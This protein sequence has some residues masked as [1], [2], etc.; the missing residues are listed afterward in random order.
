MKYSKNMLALAYTCSQSHNL[1][2]SHL[3]C[4]LERVLLRR[5]RARQL[6]ACQVHTV[7][8]AA[9]SEAP[10]LGLERVLRQQPPQARVGV[11]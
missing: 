4:A 10:V 11:V 3:C 8:K 6:H 7:H 9:L 5:Q 1:P 2:P